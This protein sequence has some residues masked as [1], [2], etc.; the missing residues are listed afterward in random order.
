MLKQKN[1][2]DILQKYNMDPTALIQVLSEIE[3]MEDYLPLSSLEFIS[4][5]L[6][7][8][9]SKI[10]GVITFYDHFKLTRPGKHL[11][12][13]CMGT[14]CFVKGAR[15]LIQTIED[16]LSIKL[17]E[18]TKDQLFTF[19]R[20]AC[21]GCCALSPVV[22]LDGLVH[23]QMTPAKVQKLLRKTIKEEKKGSDKND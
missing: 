10:Y 20:V 4:V 8:P 22:E 7:I 15:T 1:L 16:T 18:T 13:A 2:E 12:R 5:K 6:K 14:A 11:I 9:L 17:G 23:A 19:E 21:L 3:E